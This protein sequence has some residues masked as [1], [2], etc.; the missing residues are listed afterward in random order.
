MKAKVGEKKV[1]KEKRTKKKKQKNKVEKGVLPF[2][3]TDMKSTI[4][5]EGMDEDQT[6]EAI[7]YILR[8]RPYDET[9]H[10]TKHKNFMRNM[11]N[12]VVFVHYC[13]SY[14]ETNFEGMSDAGQGYVN[15]FQT[16]SPNQHD[17]LYKRVLLD[18]YARAIDMPSVPR[19]PW[20]P[21]FDYLIK[22]S[23]N[24]N[25]YIYTHMRIAFERGV[26]GDKD[27]VID[28]G[29]YKPWAAVL[30]SLGVKFV[31]E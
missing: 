30:Q 10:Y 5:D 19:H 7:Q 21:N 28:Q 2:D 3:V 22:W 11:V 4:F 6:I 31:Y 12:L 23:G 15:Y 16:V 20:N 18:L 9:G 24:M 14:M 25:N 8:V 13:K 17:V 1:K 26:Y 27:D 29:M